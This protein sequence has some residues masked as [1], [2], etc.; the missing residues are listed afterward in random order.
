M[1]VS[2]LVAEYPPSVKL[3]YT[4]LEEAGPLTFAELCAATQL[5]EQTA[6]DALATLRAAALVRSVPSHQDGRQDLYFATRP[7]Q[8]GE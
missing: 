7:E 5:H 6:L 1:Q 4:T 8:S 2:D 3:V